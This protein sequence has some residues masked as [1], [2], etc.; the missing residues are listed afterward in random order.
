MKHFGDIKKESHKMKAPGPR[1]IWSNSTNISMAGDPSWLHTA[2]NAG[3]A[4]RK[5]QAREINWNLA[6]T[7][8]IL[9]I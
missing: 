7:N 9:C 4:R 6:N 1:F 2:E 5:H 3:L 8:Q